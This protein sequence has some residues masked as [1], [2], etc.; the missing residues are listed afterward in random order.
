MAEDAIA[1]GR[2]MSQHMQQNYFALA[3]SWLELANEIE[4]STGA[5]A[6]H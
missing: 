2:G 6:G 4:R 1:A 5:G 3:K